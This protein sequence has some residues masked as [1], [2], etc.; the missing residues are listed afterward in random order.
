MGRVRSGLRIYSSPA[1]QPRFRRATD[2]LMLVP[3]LLGLVFLIVVYPPS[4]FE[5]SLE[6]FLASFPDWLAPVWGFLY[7]LLGL[8]ALVLVAAAAIS[9]RRSLA[10]E[11]SGR[12]RA[13]GGARA[14]RDAARRRLVAGPRRRDPRPRRLADVPRGAARRGRRR[15][16]HRGPHLVR[17]LRASRALAGRARLRRRLRRRSGDAGRNPRGLLVAVVAAAGV[18][19]AFGTSAGRPGLDRGCRCA[20]RARRR[21]RPSRRRGP[22]GRWRLLGRRAAIRR[23]GRCSS[24]STAATRTTR[25]SSRRSGARSGTRTTVPP[26]RLGR[27]QAAE[28]EAFVTLLARNGGVPTRE[29]V[30]AGETGARDALLVLRGATRSPSRSSAERRRSPTQLAD[31]RAARPRQYRAPARSIGSKRR[32]S[33]DDEVVL[34]RLRRRDRRAEQRISCRPTASQLLVT[35]ATVAGTERAVRRRSRFARHRRRRRATPLPPVGRAADA[36]P[37]RR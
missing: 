35:T 1:G 5:R 37:A 16:A 29:V 7:D 2:V 6:T 11:A 8:W 24:R 31:T 30:T 10:L 4:A 21:G 33:P 19:L 23:A 28:H 36:A 17:P 3:A 13:R 22:P 9:R 27:A 18:R 25:S 15:R 20:A 26:L 12:A 32:A 14:R 34:R